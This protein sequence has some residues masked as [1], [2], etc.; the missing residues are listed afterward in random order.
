MSNLP[1]FCVCPF[2]IWGKTWVWSVLSEIKQAKIQAERM[3]SN[4]FYF[5]CEID[6]HVRCLVWFLSSV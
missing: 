3:H 4:S 2:V 5:W 1:L 6:P